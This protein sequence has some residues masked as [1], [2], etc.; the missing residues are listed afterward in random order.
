MIDTHC[1]VDLFDDPLGMAKK[2]ERAQMQCI[3]VTMLPSHYRLG[4]PHLAAFD[5]VH[6]ALGLHPL[7]IAEGE[8]ELGDF[9][10]LSTACEF[11][12][13]IGL[14]FS[15]EG[16]STKSRQV[17]VLDRIL[18]SVKGRKFVTV[19]SR[20]AAPTLLQMLADAGV[21]SICFHYFTGS[22]SVA[23]AAIDAG[24]FFS[25]NRRMLMG[26]QSALLETIPRD[27]VLVESDGPF[28]TKVPINATK[29]T[30]SLIADRWCLSV[31]E[32]VAIISQNF[33][34][35]RTSD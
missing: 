25:F 21:G 28:L 2:M 20:D 29:D 18:Q 1:H 14:D 19:H 13:E 8:R 5:N 33:K 24:H 26:R 27:R 22:Q 23:T 10:S 31:P 30:Y 16:R 12:G 3:A 9:A 6:A 11:I 17:E 7:R 32:T 4:L 34:A 15:R 35:C